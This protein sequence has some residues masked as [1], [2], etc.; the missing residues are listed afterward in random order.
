MSKHPLQK[1][2]FNALADALFAVRQDIAADIFMS[3]A[4]HDG[5]FLALDKA[6]E[7]VLYDVCVRFNP[8]CWTDPFLRRCKTGP[9]EQELKAEAHRMAWSRRA[10]AGRM[11]LRNKRP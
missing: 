8:E 5:A 7:R 2:H 6:A 9:T 11:A 10:T 3:D 4:E 1:R